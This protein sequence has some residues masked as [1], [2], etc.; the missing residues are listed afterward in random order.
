MH[1]ELLR[2]KA[3]V[4]PQFP[5]A[6]LC[7]ATKPK[8]CLCSNTSVSALTLHHWGDHSQQGKGQLPAKAYAKEVV[9]PE[10]YCY[11]QPIFQSHRNQSSLTPNHRYH[12]S[13]LKG[14][15]I[16]M[17]NLKAPWHFATFPKYRSK[18]KNIWRRVLPQKG[19]RKVLLAFAFS[20]V[21]FQQQHQHYRLYACLAN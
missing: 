20:P 11:W 18:I 3:A 8:F 14:Y 13:L 17:K 6:S 12:L 4:R 19:A 10:S 1:A 16:K 5:V 7:E 21:A 2:S 9:S 15:K